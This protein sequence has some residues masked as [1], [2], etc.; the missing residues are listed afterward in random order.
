MPAECLRMPFERE[1]KPLP[2]GSVGE[3]VTF[4]HLSKALSPA[5]AGALPRGEP[6]KNRRPKPPC[7]YCHPERRGRKPPQSKDLRIGSHMMNFLKFRLHEVFDRME[8][9]RLRAKPSAQADRCLFAAP[10][11]VC[12]ERSSGRGNPSPTGL[13]G[14]NAALPRRFHRTEA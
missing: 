8:I 2:Y 6:W 3:N 12:E 14:K 9:L 13:R 5:H 7:K 10:T 1:G 11:K 4:P